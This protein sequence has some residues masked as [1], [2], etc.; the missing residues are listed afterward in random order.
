MSSPLEQDA[1]A[2]DHVGGVGEQRV[3][4]RRLARAVGAHEGVQRAGLDLER[5]APQD[6]VVVDRDVQVVDLE[7]GVSGAGRGR[8]RR[9]GATPPL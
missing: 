8:W 2:G 4:E 1:P 3:G 6:L 7:R 9:G 5:H